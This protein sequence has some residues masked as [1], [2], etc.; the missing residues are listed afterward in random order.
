MKIEIPNRQSNLI[1]V[2][3]P[4]LTSILTTLFLFYIDE[5]LYSFA[6]MKQGTAWI[7]FSIYALIFFTLQIGIGAF[8]FKTRFSFL[9]GFLI[10]LFSIIIGLA[11]CLVFFR[12]AL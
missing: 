6:W 12:S 7:I 4:L 3:F 2:L 8:V 9:K 10:A 11:L 5:G 1:A